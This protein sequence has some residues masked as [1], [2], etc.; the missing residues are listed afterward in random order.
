MSTTN[1]AAGDLA[2]ALNRSVVGI[3]A[4]DVLRVSSYIRTRLPSTG[5][6]D[7][8]VVVG[9]IAQNQTLSA[10]LHAALVG[11]K[12]AVGSVVSINNVVSYQAYATEKYYSLTD[13]F[14]FVYGIL[15]H[16]DLP[17]A[18]AALASSGDEASQQLTGAT[19]ST[20]CLVINPTDALHCPI[21]ARAATAAFTFA[22]KAHAHSNTFQLTVDTTANS[23]AVFRTVADWLLRG[24]QAMS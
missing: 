5:G 16:Y 12:A 23:T 11:G 7:G 20:R 15:E 3:Q 9:T 22:N 18:F 14:A 4:A 19:S 13:Y 8:I 10:A 1:K 6:D 2:Q 17:D 24:V 21:S